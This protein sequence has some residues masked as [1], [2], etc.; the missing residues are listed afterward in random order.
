MSN[1]KFVEF[2]DLGKLTE[3]QRPKKKSDT[4]RAQAIIAEFS[5]PLFLHYCR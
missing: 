2:L 5:T 3:S 4:T 1:S